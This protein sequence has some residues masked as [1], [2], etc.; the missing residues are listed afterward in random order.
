MPDV[1]APEAQNVLLVVLDTVRARSTFLG[2]R[3][4]T[5]T[6]QK[7]G[8]SGA[9]FEC[10]VTPGTWTLPAHASMYTGLYPTE[11][12]ATH[13]N[14]Y[15]ADEHVTLAEQFRNAGFRTGLF[16]PNAFLTDNFNME[17]GF[18][19]VQFV[20]GEASKLF[21]GGFD[22]VRFLDE[23]E[24]ESG[25]KRLQEIANRVRQGSTAK[26]LANA[27]YFRL[28]DLL[29][30]QSNAGS[31]PAWDRSAVEGAGS[32]VDSAA[33]DGD[34]FFAM[35]NLVSAHAPWGFDRNRL[36]AIGVRPEDVAPPD[37]WRE[38]ADRSGNQ[39]A[40]TAGAFPLDETAQ[41][42]RTALYESW[43][44]A[45]DELAGKLL[46]SLEEAGVAEETLV[47]LT[48]DHGECV[49]EGEVVGHSVTVDDDVVHVPL[50]VDGPGVPSDRIT[51]PVS[52]ADLHGTLLSRTG[53]DPNAG[54]DLFDGERRSP[55]LTEVYG[56]DPD[57][58]DERYRDTA[59]KFG[60]RRALYVE[61]GRAERRY[62]EDESL[63]DETVLAELDALVEGLNRFDG[64][65]KGKT[66]EGDVETRLR[67]LGYLGE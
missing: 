66:I 33:E 51:A 48:A 35:V 28:S 31:T 15:L 46:T 11:H 7:V 5:P 54:P 8:E 16:T 24:H 37:R 58:V 65:D 45:V 4:L 57:R 17:R 18:E 26:N 32:F 41:T 21:A 14:Q 34:R 12:G 49:A 10:A 62:D 20:R 9:Q 47:V 43:V 52:L 44:R 2:G 67:E 30:G 60:L 6:L 56:I 22:P 55:A 19:T 29:G 53:V 59:R 64:D 42:V 23:R 36:A 3:D 40:Y 27:A 63:G 50:V 38:L 1:D 25:I 13:R 61:S 39:W